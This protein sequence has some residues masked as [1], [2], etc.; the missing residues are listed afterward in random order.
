MPSSRRPSKHLRPARPLGESHQ[1]STRQVRGETFLFRPVSAARA[2]K[3]YTCPGCN[4]PVQPGTAHVLAWP[5]VPEVGVESGMSQ[6]RHWHTH[7]WRI[8]N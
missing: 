2:Q 6:R 4:Q 5:R 8:A 7:C 1:V 3:R